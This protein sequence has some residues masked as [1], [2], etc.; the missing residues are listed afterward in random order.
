MKTLFTTLTIL[1]LIFTACD[2]CAETNCGPGECEKGIC[3]CPYELEGDQCEQHKYKEFD[4]GCIGTATITDDSGTYTEDLFS[5][6][7]D[8]GITVDDKVGS[9]L[10]EWTSE[11]TFDVL[12]SDG[13]KIGSGSIT[14]STITWDYSENGR[15]FKFTG[16]P[17]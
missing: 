5:I 11:S 9:H 7:V 17:K 6:S 3:N 14:G 10:I 12:N 1:T 15:T 4:A 8:F 13:D 16:S 2:K